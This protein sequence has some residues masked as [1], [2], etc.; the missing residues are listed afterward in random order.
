[1]LKKMIINTE[2]GRSHT[3][4]GN[5]SA[6]RHIF[7]D[8]AGLPPVR[9]ILERLPL[10]HGVIDRGYRIAERRM[11]L[12]LYLDGQSEFETARLRDLIADIFAPTNSPITLQCTRHDDQV[13]E[14]DCF[15]DGQIDFPQSQAIGA[16]LPVTVP[17]V[18]PDP[19]W[20]EATQLVTGIALTNGTTQLNISLLTATWDDWPILDITGPVDAG[21]VIVHEPGEEILEFS[22]AIPSGETF[23]IDLR[24]GYK[25]VRRTSDQANRMHFVNPA[26]ISAFSQMR[27][28]SVKNLRV[29]GWPFNRFSFIAAGTSGSSLA[30]MRYYRRYLSL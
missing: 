12:Q 16:G 25:T 14:I 8:G 15:L 21:F 11:T 22:S 2:D 4:F 19:G 18:A 20:R 5:T 10:S 17:L 7:L 30:A 6:I 9:R 26:S 28:L 3:L 1:M 23:R 24:A 29:F 13:R 27:M